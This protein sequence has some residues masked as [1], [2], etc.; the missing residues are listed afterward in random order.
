MLG[1][2]LVTLNSWKIEFYGYQRGNFMKNMPWA[3]CKISLMLLFSNIFTLL[4]LKKK[5]IK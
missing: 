4:F 3:R 1:F 5:E 2:F